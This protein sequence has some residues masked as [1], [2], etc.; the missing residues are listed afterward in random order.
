MDC[1]MIVDAT[2][3]DLLVFFVPV[4]GFDSCRQKSLKYCILTYI[5][6][7]VYLTLSLHVY[8][9]KESNLIAIAKKL[10]T[11]SHDDIQLKLFAGEAAPNL[12]Y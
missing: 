4:H 12:L 7:L 6:K 9:R 2:P 8:T 10:C 1:V 11:S 5:I 3:H